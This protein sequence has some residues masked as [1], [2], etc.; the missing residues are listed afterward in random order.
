MEGAVAAVL[1]AA[2]HLKQSPLPVD[3]TEEKGKAHE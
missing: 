3:A 2:A 1:N